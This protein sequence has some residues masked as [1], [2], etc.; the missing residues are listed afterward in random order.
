VLR[1]VTT[2]G[3]EYFTIIPSDELAITEYN[4]IDLQLQHLPK[5]PMDISQLQ[6]KH[7]FQAAAALAGGLLLVFLVKLFRIRRK[8]MGLVCKTP[9][10]RTSD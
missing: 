7:V 2:L 3:T 9:Y 8:M 10:D 4:I 1:E 5:V 6:G